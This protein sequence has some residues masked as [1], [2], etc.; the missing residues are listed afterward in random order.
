MSE[1][2]TDYGMVFSSAEE[3]EAWENYVEARLEAALKSPLI[4][5]EEARK[6]ADALL[7][8]LNDVSHSVA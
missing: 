1:I 6:R 2:K 7:A 4:S 8:R 5:H 3:L